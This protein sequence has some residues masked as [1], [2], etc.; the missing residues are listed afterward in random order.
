[1]PSFSATGTFT[2]TRALREGS[3]IQPVVRAFVLQ[4]TGA[5]SSGTGPRTLPELAANGRP[6][7]AESAAARA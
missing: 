1:M 7:F 6:I 4:Y 3:V 2:E 5:N